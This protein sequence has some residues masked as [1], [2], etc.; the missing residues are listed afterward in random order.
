M[1]I[2]IKIETYL[3]SVKCITYIKSIYGF[4]PCSNVTFSI[5]KHVYSKEGVSVLHHQSV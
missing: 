3:F 5:Q 4:Q 2:N 1:P